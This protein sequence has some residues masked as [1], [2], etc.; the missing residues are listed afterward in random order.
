[1]PGLI[2][3]AWDLLDLSVWEAVAAAGAVLAGGTISGLTGFGFGLVIVP[4]LLLLFPPATVVVLTTSLAIASGMPILAQDYGLVRARLITPL[5]IPALGGQLIGVQVLT[6]VDTRYIK[7]AAGAVVV[8]FAVLVARGFLIPGIR[9]RLA[10]VAAG[11]ASGVLGTSTGMPGPPVVLFLTD[12]TPE[13]RVFRASITFYFFMLNLVSILLVARTG[14]VGRREAALAV[15]LLPV[16]LTGRR[17][18]QDL[19]HRVNQ[20]QFHAISLGLLILTG[21]SAALTALFG[22]L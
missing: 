9:S 15:A 8:V 3:S 14:L 2:Q 13:P 18:G 6:G 19:L 16:A 20:A 7:L 11:L 22:L 4:V 1:V 5:L 17:I 12:R 21:S 10:P